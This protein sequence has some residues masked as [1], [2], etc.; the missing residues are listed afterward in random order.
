MLY[1]A[2]FSNTSPRALSGA[3]L[4]Q[5]LRRLSAPERAILAAEIIDGTVIIQGLTIKAIAAI[6]GANISYVHAALRCTPEER[7][8]VRRGE[9]PLV[10]PKDTARPSSAP[11]VFDWHA[12]DDDALVEAVRMI[13]I[14]RTIDAAIA[15]EH[16]RA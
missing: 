5:H 4:A 10:L 12:V 7:E 3:S 15:A 2:T 16:A 8:Q 14:D 1:S 9:R 13:G 11:T 6:S